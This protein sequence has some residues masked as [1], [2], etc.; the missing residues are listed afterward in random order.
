MKAVIAVAALI[1]NSAYCVLSRQQPN[2]DLG[3]AHFDRLDSA[4]LAKRLVRRLNARF[5]GRYP[6]RRMNQPTDQGVSF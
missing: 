6:R 5:P 2:K 1:L 4:K 3:P